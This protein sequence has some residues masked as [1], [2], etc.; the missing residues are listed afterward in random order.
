MA[1]KGSDT[2]GKKLLSFVAK[3]S[4]RVQ[5]KVRMHGVNLAKLRHEL[6]QIG[7]II[8]M[9]IHGTYPAVCYSRV[10]NTKICV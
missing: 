8:I 6:G 10:C 9:Y 4:K 7:S 3:R 2:T 5:E 1:E